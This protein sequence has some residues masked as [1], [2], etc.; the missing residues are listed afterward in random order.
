MGKRKALT[1][2]IE[3]QATAYLLE[4]PG[5]TRD[6]IA[7]GIGVGKYD[8]SARIYNFLRRMEQAGHVESFYADR[9]YMAGP[10]H[11]R[12]TMKYVSTL[13]Q[14]WNE[15]PPLTTITAAKRNA[16]PPKKHNKKKR[17]GK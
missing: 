12:F 9:Q 13:T 16:K 1:V 10:L 7:R 5:S 6:Q 4:N 8:R 17:K 14:K 3:D 2:M 15:V 11:Y